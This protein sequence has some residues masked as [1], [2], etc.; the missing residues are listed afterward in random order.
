M[1]YLLIILVVGVVIGIL[2]PNWRHKKVMKETSEFIEKRKVLREVTPIA[3]ALPQPDK[4]KVILSDEE[5]KAN[6]RRQ[7]I[8][9]RPP[10]KQPD[11]WI[12]NYVDKNGQE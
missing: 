6:F 2:I 5:I 12:E 1:T 9:Q 7:V 8:K 10:V 11:W 4:P 3:P